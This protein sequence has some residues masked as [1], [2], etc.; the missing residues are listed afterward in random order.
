MNEQRPIEQ[1]RL[2]SVDQVLRTEISAVAAAR[3]GHDA[4][5]NAI[6]RTLAA[7]TQIARGGV[8]RH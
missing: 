3:F 1:I 2:P 4:T 5:T 8:G 6:R 7:A